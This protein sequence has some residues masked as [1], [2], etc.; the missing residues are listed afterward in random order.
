VHRSHQQERSESDRQGTFHGTTSFI[1]IRA[2]MDVVG[3][4]YPKI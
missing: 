3:A 1:S 4:Y 2:G